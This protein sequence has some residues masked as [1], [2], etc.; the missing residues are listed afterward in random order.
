MLLTSLRQLPGWPPVLFTGI[1][2]PAGTMLYVPTVCEGGPDRRLTLHDT[3][4]V[5]ID[6]DRDE[7]VAGTVMCSVCGWVHGKYDHSGAPI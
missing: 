1:Q 7:Q 6:S 3:T 4:V 2:T 5:V